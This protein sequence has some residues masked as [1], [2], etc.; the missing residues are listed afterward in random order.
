MGDEVHNGDQKVRKYLFS[1]IFYGRQAVSYE[2]IFS[3]II[4]VGGV[5]QI[6]LKKM[7]GAQ[8]EDLGPSLTI[9]EFFPKK[10]YW[11]YMQR[12]CTLFG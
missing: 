7:S 10:Y 8:S 12:M 5:K 4:L 1:E 6:P 2:G 9:Q 3:R 11:F